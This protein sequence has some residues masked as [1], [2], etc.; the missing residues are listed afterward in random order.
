MVN[1][2]LTGL[3]FIFNILWISKLLPPNLI[4]KLG[5]LGLLIVGY[6][7]EKNFVGR[8]STFSNALAINVHVFYMNNPHW[9]F[10]FYANVGLL[11]GLVALIA[12]A[13]SKSLQKWLH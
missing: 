6:L 1:D 12:Y 11:M 8:I 7:V 9:F 5:P 4:Q 3:N 13:M 2:I 10:I